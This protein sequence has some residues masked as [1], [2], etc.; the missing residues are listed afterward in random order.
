MTKFVILTVIMN[1]LLIPGKI[2]IIIFILDY[3]TIYRNVSVL[4]LIISRC[5]F[6]S[7]NPVIIN[8]SGICR[9]EYPSSTIL[10]WHSLIGSSETFVFYA[11]HDC[12]YGLVF[13]FEGRVFYA[14]YT[15]K[16]NIQ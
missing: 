2:E 11:Y 12:L 3:I 15:C 16:M 13:V 8:F 14:P 6:I 5:L 7:D 4:V 1:V 10:D 9:V